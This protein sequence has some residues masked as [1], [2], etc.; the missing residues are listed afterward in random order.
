MHEYNIGSLDMRI[1]LTIVVSFILLNSLQAADWP[2]YRC[3]IARSGA[4]AE[5]VETPL[6]LEWSFEPLHT[7]RP[8]WPQPAEEAPRMHSDNAYHATVGDGTV[9]FGTSVDDRVIAVDLESATIR[10]IF[11]TLGPVRFAPTFYR[12]YVY[13]GSD[14]GFVYCLSARSGT[15]IWRYRA[16][17]GPETVL[18]N[19]RLI[20][21]WPVRTS[22]LVDRDRVYFGAG[23]FPFEGIYFCCLDA[24]TG[25][26]IWKND[27]TGSRAHDLPYGGISPQSYLVASDEVLFVPSGRAMPAAFDRETGKFLFYAAPGAKRGGTWTLLDGD[28]LL[29]GVDLSGKPE[30]V[31]YDAKTGK[32]RSAVYAWFPG[33]DMVVT[34]EVSYILTDEGIFAVNR[35]GYAEAGK[36]AAALAAEQKELRSRLSKLT[37]ESEETTEEMESLAHRILDIDGEMDRVKASSCSW[38]FRREGLTTLCLVGDLV[39]TGSDGSV[40]AVDSG[41]LLWEHRVKG[42]V[43]GFAA[44]SGRLLVSTDRGHIYCFGKSEE[45]KAKTIR[46]Y[47]IPNPYPVD[48]FTDRY[49][50][51]AERIV[52]ETGIVRGYCLVLDGGEGRLAY[53]LALRTDLQIVCLESD[54]AVIVKAQRKLESAGLWG[55]RVTMMSRRIEHL[56][57]YF[58]NLVVSDERVRTGQTSYPREGIDHV[59]RP[60]GGTY[61]AEEMKLEVR[62]GLEGAGTWTQL[63]GN[64]ANTACSMD[65]L[66]KGPFGLLWYGEPGSQELIDR[67]GRACGP[68]SMDGRLFHQGEEVVMAYDAYNGTF[69]W[70]RKIP[71]AV[72]VR[73]DV[74]GGN[75]AL[76]RDGLY[77]AAHDR[78]VR[79]DPATGNVTGEY[80]VPVDGERRWGF[81]AVHNGLLFGTAAKPLHKEYAAAWKDF[82]ESGEWR[83]RDE[84]AE[85]TWSEWKEDSRFGTLYEDYSAKSPDENL[86]MD[87]HRRGLHWHPMNEFPTWASQ[88]TPK[89]AL[90][91]RIMA[92]DALFAYDTVS[93]K[94][95][96]VHRGD[97]IPN[98]AV[99]VGDET[100]YLVEKSG[101]CEEALEEKQRLVE[102]GVYEEGAEARLVKPEES[103]VRRVVALDTKSGGVLWSKPLDLTGCGGDKMGTAFA[104]GVLL[105]FGHFSNHD[106]GFFLGNE[107]TWRRITAVDASTGDVLWSKPL[108]YL[109][110]PLI[111]DETVIIE[112]RACDLFTGEIRMRTHPLTGNPVPWE[113]L[114]PGHCCA[115]TSASAHTLFYRSYFAAIYDFTRDAGLNLFGA[116]RPG[117]WLNMIS[118]GGLMLMPEASSGCT[119]SFPIRCSFALVNR[120]EKRTSNWTVFITHGSTRPVKQ[121]ALNLGAPGDM[122]DDDGKTWLAWPRPATVSPIGYGDYAMKFDVE[123]EG[124]GYFQRDHK[125]VTMEDTDKPW[126]YTSGSLGVKKIEAPLLDGQQ[127]RYTVRL[128]FS[129]SQEFAVKVQ[130]QAFEIPANAPGKAGVRT[131]EHVEVEGNLTLEFEEGPSLLNFVEIVR[132]DIEEPAQALDRLHGV[133]ENNPSTNALVEAL[134]ELE[135]LADPSTLPYLERLWNR[136]SSILMDYKPLD[137]A[138]ISALAKVCLAV[139]GKEADRVLKSLLPSLEDETLRSEVLR[140]LG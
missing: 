130:G 31:S 2:T 58:A 119:C 7:P 55:A 35:A 85:D 116:I 60:C 42:K 73:V 6:E 110:R 89:G 88:R 93:G 109:R 69:L 43:C 41:E 124:D 108:N 104:K 8:A 22:V 10:W 13:F 62:G 57:P 106:T 14:D 77:V 39:F 9:F 126:L 51:A 96:W 34:R 127:G 1:F 128:G 78:C 125:G 111:L 97:S 68:V 131:F 46:P 98:I 103:D 20:S 44:A 11:H 95:K 25:F 27:T 100:V 99:T 63:Y 107:L 133:L 75:M 36:E 59:L 52:N 15:E 26:E 49:R 136:S 38:R 139:P 86:Y 94:L 30:K 91:G 40:A 122:K 5:A 32:G 76:A 113:F 18:G 21:L 47:P 121:M 92:G 70:K 115:V 33:R 117:C 48:E 123:V 134:E 90:T 82:V 61:V 56:P 118:A 66:V 12:G 37:K 80:A 4:T 23:V 64:P 74:D 28:R 84:I 16:G 101:D 17:P 3:D 65:E 45:K 129:A 87:F 53:E 102:K 54:P 120:P 67:H 72:R 81:I 83:C 112:P 138:V 114:R 137:P 19:G 140:R 50:E 29:A 71:G 79:L 132:E 105:F 24:A 135:R